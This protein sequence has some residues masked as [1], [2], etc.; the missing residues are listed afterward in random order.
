MGI[1]N[2]AGLQGREF[3]WVLGM[4]DYMIAGYVKKNKEPRPG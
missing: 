2:P 1:K 3:W 4:F